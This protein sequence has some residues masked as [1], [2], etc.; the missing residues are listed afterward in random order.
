MNKNNKIV[1]SILEYYGDYVKTREEAQ[2]IWDSICVET[3]GEF[4]GSY[5]AKMRLVRNYLRYRMGYEDIPFKPLF[6]RI[7]K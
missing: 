7:K 6:E 1:D 2:L 5:S 3:S 4:K